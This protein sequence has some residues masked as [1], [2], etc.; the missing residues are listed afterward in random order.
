MRW[1]MFFLLLPLSA[2]AEPESLTLDCL[3]S[4][5]ASYSVVCS[6]PTL[7]DLAGEERRLFEHHRA[8]GLTTPERLLSIQ[9]NESDGLYRRDFCMT[10]DD[11]ARCIAE[12]YAQQ[13]IEHWQWNALPPLETGLTAPPITMACPDIDGLV[14]ALLL[15]W[16]PRVMA[17]SIDRRVYLLEHRE[18]QISPTYEHGAMQLVFLS[19][20]RASLTLKGNTA[21]CVTR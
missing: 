2:N 1:F 9:L 7:R 3:A 20:E 17:L 6:D 18:D 8:S 12:S 4:A 19:P 14:Y 10:K 11:S 16:D 21:R 15:T 5:R 13:I